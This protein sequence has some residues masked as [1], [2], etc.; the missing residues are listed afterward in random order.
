[1]ESFQRFVYTHLV[2]HQMPYSNC[3]QSK[4]RQIPIENL[5]Y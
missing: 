4:A 3:L 5:A 2:E 1:M